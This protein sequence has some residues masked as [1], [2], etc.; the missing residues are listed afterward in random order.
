MSQLS[1]SHHFPTSP[2]SERGLHSHRIQLADPLHSTIV[3]TDGVN[4]QVPFEAAAAN[5]EYMMDS[6]ELSEPPLHPSSDLARAHRIVTTLPEELTA[7]NY[8]LRMPLEVDLEYVSR[9]HVVASFHDSDSHMSGNDQ[10][11]A[12]KELTV[13]MAEEYARLRKRDPNDFGYSLLRKW[14][15]L[16]AHLARTDHTSAG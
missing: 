15:A 8:A 5:G 12:I 2:P 14:K 1:L 13:W 3:Y 6:F 11:D 4:G 7:Q 16:D 10:D 9:G